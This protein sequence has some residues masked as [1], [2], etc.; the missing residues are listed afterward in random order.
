MCMPT[1]DDRSI[2]DLL[3]TARA[4]LRDVTIEMGS[5]EYLAWLE[6]AT[7]ERLKLIRAH[8]EMK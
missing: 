3:D 6:L 8:E 5:P 2:L 7:Q 4:K 1:L